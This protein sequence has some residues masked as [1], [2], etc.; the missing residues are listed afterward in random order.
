MVTAFYFIVFV[1]SL[2]LTGSFLWRNKKVDTVFILFSVLIMVNCF[3]RYMLAASRSLDTALLANDILYLGGC[4]A[5]LL[6]VMVLARLCNRKM[7]RPVLFILTFLSTFVLLLVMSVGKSSIYYKNVELRYKNGFHYLV[8]TYGPL[9]KAYPALMI[10]YAIAMLYYLIYAL[11]RR[12]EI[13]LRTVA[14]MSIVGFSVIVIYILERAF[15]SDISFLSL[16]YLVGIL[17][18]MKYF[19]RLN[20]YDMSTNIAT[21]V[22]KMSEYGYIVF[23]DKFRYVNANEKVKELYPEIHSWIVDR[24]VA[25]SDSSAYRE[26]VLYL[27]ETVRGKKE[28]Q[29]V[30]VGEKYYQ[31]NV[32][33]ISYGKKNGVGYLIELVDRTSE[34]KYYNAIEAYNANL[35]KEVA[36][37]TK[38]ILYIKDMMVLGMAEMVESRDNNTGGHI[39]RTSAVVKVFAQK[40]EEHCDEFGFDDHFLMQVAKAA[41]MHD[42]GKI[43][44]D[45][46]VLRKPGKYTPEEY[47]EMKKHP[48]EGAHI[49]ENLLQGVEEDE[50]VQIAKNV[51]LYHHEKWNGQGYPSG[52][53]GEQIPIEARIMALADVFDALVSKRCYK[54]AFSYDKAFDI[55]RESLG[56]HFDARLGEIFIECRPR[57]EAFY[58]SYAS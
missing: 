24:A 4:Y 23:D 44:I 49:V 51:A 10:L 58:D 55:I 32:R 8:K 53:K 54:D 37:Q 36:R 9:H 18:L 12:R 17:L 5:P 34:K 30:Q 41:P 27:M 48:V 42:L 6:T 14:T 21:S 16:G 45:D 31:E 28:E 39:K 47:N 57:L 46:A 35:E 7:P 22:E 11:R 1:L 40:L 3:G 52:L 25:E 15:K 20:M 19:E 33:P 2:L 38:H 29:F 26:L 43:A 50:F 13:S 56:E